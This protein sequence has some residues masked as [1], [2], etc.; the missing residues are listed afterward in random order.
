MKLLS[1]LSTVNQPVIFGLSVEVCFNYYNH[2]SNAGVV[3][4]L[5]TEP[6][7]SDTLTIS[8]V[9]IHIQLTQKV[10]SPQIIEIIP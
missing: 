9:L 6:I 7:I 4:D 1:H 8:V 3:K 10:A 5:L 2:S